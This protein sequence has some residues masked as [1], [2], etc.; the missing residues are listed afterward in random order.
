MLI[1]ENRAVSFSKQKIETKRIQQRD[2]GKMDENKKKAG[3][4]ENDKK[5]GKNKRRND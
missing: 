1:N 3:D 4:S 5:E 2:R